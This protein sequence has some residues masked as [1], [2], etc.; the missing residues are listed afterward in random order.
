MWNSGIGIAAALQLPS[1]VPAYPYS[2]TT[3]EQPILFEFDRRENPLRDELLDERFDPNGGELAVPSK[4]GLGVD[5]NTDALHRYRLD[6]RPHSYG[7]ITVR[8]KTDDQFSERSTIGVIATTILTAAIA[9]VM[10]SPIR[11][12]SYNIRSCR[13]SSGETVWTERREDV[14]NVVQAN[15]PDVVGLQEPHHRQLAFLRDQL[16]PYRFVGRGRN[17]GNHEGEITAIGFNQQRFRLIDRE[18]FWLSETPQTSGSV[19]WDAK[20]PRTVT[21]VTLHDNVSGTIFDVFNTH[22]DHEGDRARIEGA[23]L[24]Y[25]KAALASQ[26]NPVLITGDFNAA[27][28][29]KTYEV[30]LEGPSSNQLFYDAKD[31]SALNQQTPSVTYSGDGTYGSIE[32]GVKIDH[33]FVTPH[34][35]VLS[36]GVLSYKGADRYPSDH[37]PL[38]ASVM[39]KS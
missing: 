21:N 7:P 26:E 13:A 5:I 10:Q 23:R 35:N 34:W 28:S 1:T 30:M 18:T 27:E 33:I 6:E 8:L 15:Q 17:D 19:G 4:P 39:I 31:V 20:Y 9:T 2:E 36:H 38:V 25:K 11:V 3:T 16:V 32:N 37:L 24:L 29:S 14:L 12:M 22:L